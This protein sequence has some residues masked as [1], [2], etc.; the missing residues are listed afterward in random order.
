MD[1]L[2]P[3]NHEFVETHCLGCSPEDVVEFFAS[4]LT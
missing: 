4:A 2:A 3:N 1:S